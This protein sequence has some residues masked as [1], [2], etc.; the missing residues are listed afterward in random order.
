MLSYQASPV[1]LARQLAH[2]PHLAVLDSAQADGPKCRFDIVSAMPRKWWTWQNN[3]LSGS[4]E[5]TLTLDQ[6]ARFLNQ[7]QLAKDSQTRLPFNGGFIGLLRYSNDLLGLDTKLTTSEPVLEVGLYDWALVS[8]HEQQTTEIYFHPFCSQQR[9]QLI[10]QALAAPEPAKGHFRLTSAWQAKWDKRQYLQAFEQVKRYLHSGDCYQINL[11]QA[12]SANYHGCLLRAYEQLRSAVGSP[13]SGYFSGSQRTILSVSP[14][15]LLRV[16]EA[17]QIE[18][19]PIKGTRPRAAN[20]EQDQANAQ[21]LLASEKDRAEN[22]MIV[23]LLR[24]DLGKVAKPG[25]V[26]VPTLFGL[27][28]YRNVHHMVSVVQAELNSDTSALQCLFSASP[29]GSITGAPK[30]RAMEIIDELEAQPRSAYCGSLFYQSANGRLD[31][32]ILIRTMEADAQQLT[33]NGGGGIVYDSNGE[34]E[35]EESLAKIRRLMQALEG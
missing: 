1:S 9:R 16:N 30:R 14:E 35:Y 27:E 13:F 29:G 8:D 20:A 31:A 22:V 18:A 12:F 10:T 19:R 15:R 34:A 6:L 5:A 21:A 17:K 4:D 7:E 24:N 28:S 33:V 23:D 11:T 32:S 26:S 2:L 25:S 3:Q